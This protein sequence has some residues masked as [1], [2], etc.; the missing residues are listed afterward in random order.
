[1]FPK[2]PYFPISPFTY[3]PISLYPYFL[4]PLKYFLKHPHVILKLP[5]PIFFILLTIITINVNLDEKTN[6]IQYNY[7]GLYDYANTHFECS[8]CTSQT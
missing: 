4:I 3:T 6:K 1:M 2:Y 7:C 8:G 5:N